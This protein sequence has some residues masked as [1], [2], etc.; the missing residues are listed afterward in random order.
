MEEF[1]HLI[2]IISFIGGFIFGYNHPTN[3]KYRKL[4]RKT[5]DRKKI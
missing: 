4:P 3:Q 5:R 2:A 1:T